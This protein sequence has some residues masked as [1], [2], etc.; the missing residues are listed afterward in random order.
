MGGKAAKTGLDTTV[1]DVFFY[2]GEEVAGDFRCWRLSGFEWRGRH[3]FLA[4][5]GFSLTKTFKNSGL[6]EA[7]QTRFLRRG[8]EY[9]QTGHTSE[10]D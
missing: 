1:G 3:I 6:R 2:L 7:L 10:S 9:G 5:K 8:A 4:L